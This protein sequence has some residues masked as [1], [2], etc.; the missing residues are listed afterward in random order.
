VPK[1]S[2]IFFFILLM[3]A[4]SGS[5]SAD[6][7][8]SFD[9]VTGYRIAHYRAAVPQTVPGGTRIDRDKLDELVKAGAVLLDVM[10]SEGGGADLKTGEWRLLRPHQTIPGATWL[11]DVGK[12]TLKIEFETYLKTNALKV[13]G[14]DIAKPIIVFCQ[15]DCWMGWNVV[16]RLAKLGHSK[17]Y[18]FPEGTD[19]WVE[20]G[21]RKLA[22]VTPVPL[23]ETPATSQ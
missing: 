10:P 12:G 23:Q 3:A 9:T 5:M 2:L 1:S 19:G 13:S 18:W 22:P 14:G 8:A 16:Q 4:A 7:T 6:D 21:D 11:P 20:W 17:V 15:S